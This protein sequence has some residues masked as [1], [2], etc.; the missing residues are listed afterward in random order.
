[1]E[2]PFFQTD[3]MEEVVT[4]GVVDLCKAIQRH[5]HQTD[6][7]GGAAR[8]HRGGVASYLHRVTDDRLDRDVVSQLVFLH[9]QV[10]Y[11]GA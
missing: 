9:V 5:R 2:H 7:A 11:R 8:H 6:G 1:M 3:I 10:T 4:T